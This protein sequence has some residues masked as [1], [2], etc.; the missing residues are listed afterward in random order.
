MKVKRIFVMGMITVILLALN[1]SVVLAQ[2]E[3]PKTPEPQ[4]PV[5]L[6]LSELTGV[7]YEE[8]I[9]LRD[10]GFG[11]G[12]FAKAYYYI[13]EKGGSYSEVLSQAQA[14]GWGKFFKENGMHPGGKGRGLGSLIGKG[15]Q[16]ESKHTGP[17]EWAGGP[18]EHANGPKNKTDD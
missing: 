6:F 1:S 4:N 12:N 15:H 2:D 9:T 5:A 13:Q 7:P 3:P 14:M 18:P 11:F 17:P 8:I 16:E 10:S